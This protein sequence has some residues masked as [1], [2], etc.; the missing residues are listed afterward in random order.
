MTPASSCHNLLKRNITVIFTRGKELRR[1]LSTTQMTHLPIQTK[2]KPVINSLSPRQLD[3][4]N[5]RGVTSL[6]GRNSA[7]EIQARAQKATWRRVKQTI[8]I[9]TESSRLWVCKRTKATHKLLTLCPRQHQKIP[10]DCEVPFSK[11]SRTL[12][13]CPRPKKKVRQ[14]WTLKCLIEKAKK[15]MQAMN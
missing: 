15:L 1:R 10:K 5:N 3:L 7:L 12:W 2:T 9:Q 13:F 11:K 4:L 14:C 8:N 6:L